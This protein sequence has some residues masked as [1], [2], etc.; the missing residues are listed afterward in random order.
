MDQRKR[1]KLNSARQSFANPILEATDQQTIE[2]IIAGN[3][4]RISTNAAIAERNASVGAVTANGGKIQY[5]EYK[6]EE[7]KDS[8]NSGTHE[9]SFTSLSNDE[10]ADLYS[11]CIKLSTEN[12]CQFPGCENGNFTYLP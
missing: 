8:L 1:R 10:L 9:K 4:T 5:S 6:G 12:V 3:A 11:N 2:S 7:Q